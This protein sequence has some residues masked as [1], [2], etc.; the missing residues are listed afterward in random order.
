MKVSRDDRPESGANE[1]HERAAG[2]SVGLTFPAGSK[3]TVRS[4][5][6]GDRL[7]PLGAPG[8]RRLK[9]VL[10]DRRVPRGERGRIPL[11]CCDGRIAWVP[12]VTIDQSFR[13]SPHGSPHWMDAGTSWI[14]EIT[15]S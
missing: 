11:L 1:G 6:P 5:R 4:R 15:H 12:G 2:Q 7:H 10:I 3:L 9:E 8:S 13:R 14:A